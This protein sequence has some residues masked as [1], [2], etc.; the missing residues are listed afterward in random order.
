LNLIAAIRPEY[1]IG[2][3]YYDSGHVPPG[4]VLPQDGPPIHDSQAWFDGLL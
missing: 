2:F 1:L 4:Q 3:R